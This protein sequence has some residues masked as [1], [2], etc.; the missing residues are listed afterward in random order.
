MNHE[1]K[2]ALDQAIDEVLVEMVAGE[3]RRVD[4]ASVRRAVGES[5]SPRVPVWFAAAAVLML[6]IGGALLQRTASVTSPGTIA[7]TGTSPQPGAA[8]PTPSIE[9]AQVAQTV[10][11]ATL[12]R[13]KTRIETPFEPPYEG[14]PRLVVASID[15]PEPLATERLDA[16][17]LRITRIEITPLL[18]S[19]LPND[20]EPKP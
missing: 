13:R 9:P 14:L 8:R 19:T 2:D 20:N 3:P 7:Q 12:V 18:V 16:D 5:R 1:T 10:A 6:A 15:L 17:L 11:T 4:A